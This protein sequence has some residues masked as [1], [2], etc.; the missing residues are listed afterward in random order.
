MASLTLGAGL[1]VWFAREQ[2]AQAEQ[3]QAQAARPGGANGRITVGFI[4]VGDRAGQLIGDILRNHRNELQIVAVCDPDQSHVMQRAQQV[5]GDPTR[6]GPAEP[7]G[8]RDFRDLV[9][10]NDIDVCFVVTPDHW[11]ALAAGAALRAGKDVYCEK[12]LTLTINEGKHLVQVSRATNKLLQTGSQQRTEYGGRFRLACELVRNGRIGTVRT[13]KTVIGAN[14][15]GGPF[16]VLSVPE[17]FDYNLWLGPTPEAPYCEHRTHYDF[18]WWQAY[19]GGKMTDWGAHHNDIA[20]WALNMDN[21]GPV[22]VERVRA[23]AA[24]NRPNCYNWFPEFE[25]RYTYANGANGA[26]GTVVRCMSND[27]ETRHDNGVRFEGDNG[28]W[29]FVGRGT[30]TASDRRLIDEPLPANAVRLPVGRNQIG[31]FVDCV[32]N[33]QQPICNVQV[34]HRS[35]TVCHLGNIALL[36]NQRLRWNPEQE[37]FVDNGQ[38]NAMLSRQMRAPWRL[39]PV[40]QG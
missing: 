25:V 4:G 33:R 9:R 18:R 32:R 36:L 7:A 28:Q 35:C 2:I 16:R 3:Q 5:G 10:R 37:Q 14:P 24:D 15:T 8:R 20:Q 19:S 34:G 11:H 1:P 21:S 13:I 40:R 27:P 38:A 26:N 29:I 30:L 6:Y 31:N 23:T 12:P 17:S 39:E 22:L